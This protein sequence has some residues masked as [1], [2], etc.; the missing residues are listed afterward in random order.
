MKSDYQRIAQAIEFINANAKQ[1]P[2]LENIAAHLH[3]SP[4]HFQRLFSQWAGVAPKKY[5]QIL[6]VDRAKQLLAQSKPLAEVSD[7]VGLSG[8]S[9][10]HDHFVQLEA[11]SPGEFKAGGA[12]MEIRY[13]VIGGPFGDAFIAVTP[14]GICKLSFLSNNNIEQQIVDLNA[15]WPAAKLVNQA[16]ETTQM[17]EALFAGKQTINGPLSLYVKGTNFQI[18]VWRALLQIE[19]GCI[20]SYVQVAAAVG[21]PRA[22]RAVG[23][24]IGSN[25]VAFFIPC[26]RVLQQSGQIGGY[27]WGE[28]RKHAIHAWESARY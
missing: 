9:R 20:S 22:Y 28:T 12:G 14:R 18:N 8:S 11:A 15:Q 25:Q 17:V 19:P 23:T 6:T 5:L 7:S 24:A 4:F 27:L 10:L 1:Q 16:S 21:K 3:L 26:H 2:S 13:S